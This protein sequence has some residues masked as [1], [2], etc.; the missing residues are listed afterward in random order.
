MVLESCVLA[1]ARGWGMG[2]WRDNG[3]VEIEEFR[4]MIY[5]WAGLSIRRDWLS[6]SP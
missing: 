3:G 1:T 5:F 4:Q 6:F 2:G